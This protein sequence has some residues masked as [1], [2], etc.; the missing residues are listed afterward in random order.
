M[1]RA[2]PRRKHFVWAWCFARRMV[3]RRANLLVRTS[4]K[5]PALTRAVWASSIVCTAP[6]MIRSW[7]WDAGSVLPV[8]RSTPCRETGPRLLTQMR[9]WLRLARFIAAFVR[10]AST[11]GNDVA[12]TSR[13][14]QDRVISSLSQILSP[15]LT[16]ALYPPT[17]SKLAT[18]LPVEPAT[19][20]PSTCCRV[21]PRRLMPRGRHWGE[22]VQ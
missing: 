17:H 6:R 3:L 12:W 10:S 18:P 8:L 4:V 2:R 20:L 15:A 9:L 21:P 1:T 14:N 22:E 7:R 16:S 5:R 13:P 19:F 11:I